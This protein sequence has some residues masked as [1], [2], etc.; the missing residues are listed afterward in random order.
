MRRSPRLGLA[1]D[2]QIPDR[3]HQQIRETNG[4]DRHQ[5]REAAVTI[6]AVMLR[7][8]TDDRASVR[9]LR[10]VLKFAK[11]RGLLATYVRE[12]R[13][14]LT[15]HRALLDVQVFRPSSATKE[16]TTMDMR[17][18]KKPRFLRVENFRDA[19]PMR[20]AGV[21]PGKYNKPDLVF[22]NGDKLGLSA[23]NIETLAEAYGWDSDMWIGHLIEL[24][25]GK[26]QFGGKDVDMVLLK[27]LSKAEGEEAAKE[28][29][30][31][32]APNKPPQLAKPA[33]GMDDEIP[34]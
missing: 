4:A 22:E 3:T 15:S 24:F 16:I 2:T 17:Q 7:A 26:G 14:P 27:P 30:K 18:F 20:I 9:A 29:T 32:K 28:P 21:V 1:R 12:L 34:F 6:Y 13:S 10:A 31:K 25:V 11:R 19:R 33:G 5:A 8:T 23:T